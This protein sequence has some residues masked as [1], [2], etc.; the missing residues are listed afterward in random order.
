MGTAIFA[1]G[2]YDPG[3]T[4]LN[5]VVH[6]WTIEEGPMAFSAKINPRNSVDSKDFREIMSGVVVTSVFEKIGNVKHSSDPE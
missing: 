4:S 1:Y 2:W 3:T 6:Y 5:K